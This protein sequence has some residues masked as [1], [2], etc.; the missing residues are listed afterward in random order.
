MCQILRK[1]GSELVNDLKRYAVAARCMTFRWPCVALAGIL[2]TLGISQAASAAGTVSPWKGGV[3]PTAKIDRYVA[4][5]MKGQHIPGLEVGLYRRGDVLLA[6][7]YGLASVELNVPVRPEMVFQSGSVGKQF[8]ATALMMLVEEGKVSLDDSIRKYFDHAPEAWQ[9]I[10]V[11]HLLSHTSGLGEYGADERTAV[12]GAFYLRQDLTEAQMLERVESMAIDF[13]PGEQWRY[14]NT[15]FVLLGFIIHKITGQFY[16]DFLSQRIFKPL[17]MSATRV[18]SE[19]D[20]IPNRTVGYEIEHGVLRNQTWVSPTF[21][22][23]ADG[24]LY[25]NVLDLARWDGALYGEQLLKQASLDRMWTVFPLND[26]QPNP[27]HY[28][29]GW[30]I[31]DVHGHKLIEHGGSWQ[32]FRSHIARYV[33]DGVTVVVLSNVGPS[34]PTLIAHGIAG[35]L[36]PA[37]KP[38]TEED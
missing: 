6:K 3:I 12:Y 11:K 36:D 18:I 22:T 7:G 37:L 15:N 28:G 1:P 32:G 21:N 8:T 33:D 23:T 35:L 25:F 17:S 26:G 4:E 29:F 9:A 31:R 30:E 13:K 10:K 24:A 38:D 19:S 16:G 20:I 5:Q 34:N 2:A 27:G 14:T